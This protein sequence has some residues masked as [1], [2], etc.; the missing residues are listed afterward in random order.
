MIIKT[1]AP[2]IILSIMSVLLQ[3]SFAGLLCGMPVYMAAQIGCTEGIIV[4]LSAAFLSFYINAGTALF[5][6]C[7]GGIIGLS[8]GIM[9]DRIRSIYYVPVI[10]AL[11]VLVMLFAVN[12]LLQIRIF[13]PSPYRG[14][15]VQADLLLPLLYVYCLIHF[16]ISLFLDTTLQ[17]IRSG[18][19]RL[20]DL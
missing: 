17:H 6:I 1:A 15:L 7:T 11:S 2:C 18:L 16:K 13:D 19:S 9:K 4:F 12:Y 20:H 5:F 3:N 8:S 14:P 10:S